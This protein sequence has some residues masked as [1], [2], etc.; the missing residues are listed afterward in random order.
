MAPLCGCTFSANIVE[1]L[2]T[3]VENLHTLTPTAFLENSG[4]GI[5]VADIAA[6]TP[7]ATKSVDFIRDAAVDAKFE[8][9]NEIKSNRCKLYLMCDKASRKELTLIFQDH[10]MV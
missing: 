9:A 6:W 10:I 3:I 5:N 7:S 8:V 4:R 2:H 1:N